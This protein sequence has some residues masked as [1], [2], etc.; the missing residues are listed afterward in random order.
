MPVGKHGAGTSNRQMGQGGSPE[1]IHF[2]ERE[3]TVGQILDPL[4][5]AVKRETPNGNKPRQQIG[6]RRADQTCDQA[7]V[8]YVR[9]VWQEKARAVQT[10]WTPKDLNRRDL[11]PSFTT[12][13]K[14]GRKI[15][16]RGAMGGEFGFGHRHLDHKRVRTQAAEASSR[17]L[18]ESV[19][20]HSGAWRC[21]G[22]TA[23]HVRQGDGSRENRGRH[24]SS[25]SRT[26]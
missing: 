18:E 23:R 6:R 5:V 16:S 2:R 25:A 11:P 12:R 8:E 19:H 21:S 10:D 13:T 4:A 17:G 20:S 26:C 1:P 7:D 14:T 3:E 9:M 22:C 24:I 15:Q